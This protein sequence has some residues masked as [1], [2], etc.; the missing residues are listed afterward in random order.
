MKKLVTL[1]LALM[2]ALLALLPAMAEETY[3]VKSG[4][5]SMLNVSEE[6]MAN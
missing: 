5:L 4:V 6:E 1:T 2:I 3:T